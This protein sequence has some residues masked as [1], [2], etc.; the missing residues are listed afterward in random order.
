MTALVH[1]NDHFPASITSTAPEYPPVRRTLLAGV[2]LAVLGFGGFGTWAS[3]APLASAAVAPGIIVADTNRKTIQ[4]L[5]GGIIAEILVRDGD[6]VEAGQTLM[7]LDDLETRSTVTLLEDQRRAYTAQEAR[8]LAERDGRN[9]LVF[10]Q[11]LE[12][13]RGEAQTDEILTGQQ[14]IFESYRAS[15]QGRIEVTRQRIAQ[16]GAQIRAFEAQL[17][18]G[19]RQLVLIAQEM[20]GVQELFDKGLERKPRL[21]A[22]KRA[23]AELDGEQGEFSN[24]MAQA[25]EAIAEA[26]MEILALQAPALWEEGER[27]R[28][29]STLI[30]ALALAEP[31]GY[32]RT[33][34]D[35]GPKMAVLISELLEV[36]Q[37]GQLYPPNRVSAHYLRKLRA[38]LEQEAPDLAS[39]SAELP[40]PLSERELEV[41]T[42]IAAGKTNQEIA[43]ELFVAKS[44]VKTHIKN[45][46]RK[47]HTHNRTQALARARELKLI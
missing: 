38:A 8:L 11:D 39:P 7:Q 1:A 23:A 36:Q 4:H 19:G 29:V 17:D 12:S 31:E 44:T 28:A 27:E 20:E 22:L 18:S 5:D 32:V 9:V 41:L 15:L 21:L 37:R 24:R 16:Y 3:L 14:R 13:L 42:L 10:P 43:G 25:R 6:H 2:A 33:F 46:Y 40:E 34:V 47:F 26:E 45:I 30:H 35:E